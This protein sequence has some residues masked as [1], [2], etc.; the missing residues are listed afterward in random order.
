MSVPV[1]VNV[2]VPTS[3]SLIYVTHIPCNSIQLSASCF[4]SDIHFAH[5]LIFFDEEEKIVHDLDNKL[6]IMYP[7]CL[8]DLATVITKVAESAPPAFRA[9]P[10]AHH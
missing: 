2:L 4:G 7:E 8:S 9:L 1:F 10:D 6:L 3:A 5:D